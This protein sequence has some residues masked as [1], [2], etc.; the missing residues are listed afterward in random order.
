MDYAQF[1][2]R[3]NAVG[4]TASGLAASIGLS[5]TVVSR[6]KNGVSKPSPA[7]ILKLGEELAKREAALGKSQSRSQDAAVPTAN[8]DGE[9]HKRTSYGTNPSTATPVNPSSMIVYTQDHA[10]LL[11]GIPKGAEV[12][13]IPTKEFE[14]GNIV[15]CILDGNTLVRRYSRKG[16]VIVLT[17]SNP[18]YPA[19]V[20][21]I[22]ALNRPGNGMLG[23]CDKVVFHIK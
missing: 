8:L 20:T 18:K 2:S 1:L 6:W 10:M 14:E 12:T 21:D 17:S 3:C 16:D 13:I 9:L 22:A 19:I 5:R 11:D 4:M 7:T 15:A 23:V